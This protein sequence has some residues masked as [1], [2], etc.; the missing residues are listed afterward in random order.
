MTAEAQC[1]E[2]SPLRPVCLIAI[3]I[4]AVGRKFFVLAML[5]LIFVPSVP[6]DKTSISGRA[7]LVGI[8][9]LSVLG[10]G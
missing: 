3:A 8:A 6:L 2:S 1:G 4:S 10:I 9:S 7:T 5:S